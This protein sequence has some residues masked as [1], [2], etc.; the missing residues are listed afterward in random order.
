MRCVCCF[1][2]LCA[3]LGTRRSKLDIVEL[4]RSTSFVHRSFVS[5]PLLVRLEDKC[6]TRTAASRPYP[7]QRSSFSFLTTAAA[8][9]THSKGIYIPLGHK[10][11]IPS[12]SDCSGISD[13]KE[14]QS[15]LTLPPRRG[16]T[17]GPSLR[18]GLAKQGSS[19]GWQFRK[20]LT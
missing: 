9:I 12:R 17:P 5:N 2:I 4:W 13:E 3:G 19:N 1:R 7:Q 8:I 10:G 18:R 6:Y 14:S 15:L 16:D 20:S 11:G